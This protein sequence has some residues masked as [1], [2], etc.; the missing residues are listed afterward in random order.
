WGRHATVQL[1]EETAYKAALGQLRA[2]F[3]GQ[4][5]WGSGQGGLHLV[6]LA[7]PGVAPA[8]AVHLMRDCMRAEVALLVPEA[9][10]TPSAATLI[11][12]VHTDDRDRIGYEATQAGLAAKLEEVLVHGVMMP[13]PQEPPRPGDRTLVG[14]W[15]DVHRNLPPSWP[16][17]S[18]SSLS[19]E[20][21][22]VS[23]CIVHHN[24]PEMLLQAIASLQEQEYK[25]IEVVVYD[26]GSDGPRIPAELAKVELEL[27]KLAP[28]QGWLL[29]SPTIVTLG[30]ARNAAAKARYL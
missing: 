12:Q 13:R 14:R 16:G 28:N 19:E 10:G 5:G 21:P 25:P 4:P 18:T 3:T 29:R 20:K 27:A 9:K 15:M 23:V 2:V 17:G 11:G 24:R 26:N 8:W 22:L 1:Q 7:L 30:T 6:V